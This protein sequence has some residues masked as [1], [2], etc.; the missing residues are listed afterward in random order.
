MGWNHPDISLEEMI[1]LIK[2][3]V[4]ILILASG[5]QSSGLLAHWDSYNIKRAF[6]W[7]HFFEN[8]FRRLRCFDVYQ[9]S[10]VEL[11]AA[12]IEMTSHPAFPQG[13]VHLSSATLRRARSFLLEHLLHNL[14]LRDSHLQA[15]L[16]AIIEIDLSDLSMTEH[17]CLNAYLN[18]LTLQNRICMMD[19]STFSDVTPSMETENFTELTVHELFRRQSSVSC[20]SIIEEGVDVL[21]NVVK[22]SSWK[23]SDCSLFREQMSHE[24]VPALLPIAEELVDFVTWNQWKSRALSYFLDKRTI[25]LVS[26]A[27]LI[28]SGA[29]KQW[30]KVF[31]QLNISEKSSEDDLHETIELLLLGSIASRWNCIIE[32]LMSVSYDSVP[33]SKQYH[34]LASSVFEISQTEE[35]KKSK[36]GDILDYLM[37]LLGGQIHLLWKSSP[38]L[39]AVSLPFWPTLY[40]FYLSDIE[41]QFQGKPSMIRCCNCIQDSNEHKDCELAERIWCLYIFHVCGSQIIRGGAV[42]FDC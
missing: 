36:E 21:A 20:I 13:L 4:D 7:A 30:R 12:L 6:Q 5:Y 14:P 39:A 35:I 40:R 29:N 18:D 11:D 2:G 32:H 24:T 19:T 34:V 3:F 10:I 26:G 8:A 15:V 41:I 23:D 25:R 22:N 1:K 33:I 9:E 28:F 42:V 31:G 37:E 27:S 38:A 17:D 16:T